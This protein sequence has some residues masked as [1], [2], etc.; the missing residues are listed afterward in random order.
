MSTQATDEGSAARV[1]EA[2]GLSKDFEFRVAKNSMAELSAAAQSVSERLVGKAD[3]WV[4]TVANQVEVRALTLSD[5]SFSMPT[6]VH[7]E[8]TPMLAKPTT[9]IIDGDNI[10][11]CSVGFTVTGPSNSKGILTA[12]HCNDIQSFA[13]VN[14]PLQE[15]KWYGKYDVQWHKIG[16]LTPRNKVK[17]GGGDTSTITSI[18]YAVPVV[19]QTVCKYG[20]ATGYGCGTIDNTGFCATWI[21]SFQ[22]TYIQFHNNNADLSS[23]GDSGGPIFWVGSAWGTTSGE[24]W[25]VT[26]LCAC[27]NVYT[28]IE[29][30]IL[31]LNVTPMTH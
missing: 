21:P 19:G 20:N 8:L 9:D 7:T 25:N 6:F 10:S 28:P 24:S 12:G 1:A 23:P 2:A 3:V 11:G 29:Y 16:S 15:E 17:L 30:A 14:L 27:N 13:G 22:C 18:H 26:R 5:V 31:G 4:D